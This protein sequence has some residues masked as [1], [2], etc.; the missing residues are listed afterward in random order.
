MQ[1]GIIVEISKET[2]ENFITCPYKVYRTSR[3]ESGHKTEY[4][5]IFKRVND[6]YLADALRKHFPNQTN[7]SEFPPHSFSLKDGRKTFSRININFQDLAS[8][9]TAERIPR[10]SDL[11]AFSYIP[12]RFTPKE[13]LSKEDKLAM[14]F[15][16]FI[17][18][19]LQARFP[20]QGKVIHGKNFKVARAEMETYFLKVKSIISEI[21]KIYSMKETAPRLILNKHCQI[22]EFKESCRATAV[23]KD[24]LSLLAG[25]SA[26]EIAE[27]HKKGI[28]TVT[29]YSYTFRPKRKY[30][31]SYHFNL[32]ALAIREKKIH[33]YG[34]PEVPTTSVRIYLDVEGDPERDFYYLVGM[35]ILDG[36]TEKK[37]SFWA[38][39]EEEERQIFLR[40]FESLAAYP[41]FIL[42]HYG[43][44]EIRFMRKAQKVLGQDHSQ[45]ADKI[46]S[47][48]VNIL[49]IIY[50]N[51]FFPTYSNGLK[52]IGAY[53]GFKW[54][55]DDASGIQSLVWRK[56]FEL[57]QERAFKEKLVT[58]NMDDCEALK[59]VTNFIYGIGNK[60]EEGYQ[61]ISVEDLKDESKHK[62]GKVDFVL[63][64]LDFVNNRAYFDYQ[65]QKVFY[66]TNPQIKNRLRKREIGKISGGINRH[67]D[68]PVNN[69]CF[70][71]GK[72]AYRSGAFWKKQYD[73]KF[74]KSGIRKWVVIYRAIRMRCEHCKRSQVPTALQEISKYGH[75]IQSW[76]IYHNI[77]HHQPFGRIPM[78][79]EAF[80][81]L[82]LPRGVIHHFKRY[83]AEYYAE[84][85]RA[86][87]DKLNHGGLL[88][89]DETKVNIKGRR[90]YVWVMTNMEEVA[91]IHTPTREG[92]FL[93]EY[94]RDFRGVL[95]SDFYAV[96][97][98]I[99][100]V[101]QKC[102]I[103]LIRD[104]NDDLRQNPFDEEY[105]K[106][107]L[108]F[109]ALLKD[110]MAT[111]DR[112]G[113]KK[114]Y[115]NKHKKD[116]KRYFTI[117]LRENYKSEVALKYQKRLQK[118]SEKL[119]S[120]LNYDGVPWNNNNAE[121]AIKHFADYRRTVAG[122]TR[123]FGL[124]NYLMLLSIYQT[125]RYKGMSFLKFLLTKEKVIDN[126][127]IGKNPANIWDS[128]DPNYNSDLQK[129]NWII[130]H[131]PNGQ[132]V[133]KKA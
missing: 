19:N 7:I 8:C 1:N 76:A 58:Y 106:M 110:I 26:K 128:F 21:R 127:N 37:L 57:S 16:G 34:N 132:I 80:F 29:Q 99:D 3:N 44:Y 60:R 90:E 27:Q 107:I 51:I 31:K 30:R 36:A 98:S 72:R 116:V 25:I 54:S 96:Y 33:I 101:Q 117:V 56:Q 68:I 14:A 62:W 97:D 83:A 48:S 18:G 53:L 77:V 43:S 91:F 10:H 13:N 73:L 87:L 118:N 108:E 133:L 24:D 38:D 93:K 131:R 20:S 95:I 5:I 49:A 100:C 115:L 125:C 61:V 17:L 15:D 32:K 23:E 2:F 120:F 94:L 75:G 89:I 66:K 39:S 64:D 103:H 50:S 41:E 119:F 63:K 112:Y 4:E 126:Y 79:L 129:Y 46:L 47:S 59:R 40:F 109:S 78:D 55:S 86:I 92:G 69:K 121:H 22:C 105:K 88:H 84:T 114:R 102:L 28:F 113:L 6:L 104:M 42:Y 81:G 74:T 35:I 71:C 65:R 12:V 45:L 70:S 67:I 52:D 82:R 111:V 123:E 9:C 85:Y 11:G 130:R 122:Q 124:K